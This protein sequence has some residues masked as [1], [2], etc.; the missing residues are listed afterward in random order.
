MSCPM[1]RSRA[2]LLALCAALAACESDGGRAATLA[3]T[4]MPGAYTADPQA[5]AQHST[6]AWWEDGKFGIFI[7]DGVV[8]M[9]VVAIPAP[10]ATMGSQR[11]PA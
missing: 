10:T 3:N 7:P 4:V 6:P 5:H 11:S 2:A 9:T 1:Q 8:V